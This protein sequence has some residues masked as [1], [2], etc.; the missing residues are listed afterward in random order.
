MLHGTR[1]ARAIPFGHRRC[2]RA[3]GRDRRRAGNAGPPQGA[4][5]PAGREAERGIASSPDGGQSDV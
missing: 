1:R 5:R 2:A 4:A 3:T